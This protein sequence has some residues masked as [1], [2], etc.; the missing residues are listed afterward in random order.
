MHLIQPTSH[1]SSFLHSHQPVFI[2]SLSLLFCLVSANAND[3]SV[4]CMRNKTNRVCAH[5][6]SWTAALF[7]DLLPGTRTAPIK[8]VRVVWC[9]V[10]VELLAAWGS[11]AMR[12]AFV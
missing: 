9:H 2:P 8:G 12:C 5:Q 6:S 7:S 4:I 1:G 11:D 10:V 3:L